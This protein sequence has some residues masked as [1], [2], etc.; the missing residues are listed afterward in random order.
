MKDLRRLIMLV[1]MILFAQDSEERRYGS[2]SHNT[3][4]VPRSGGA[5]KHM[6]Q[7]NDG[8]GSIA[9]KDLSCNPR[10][11]SLEDCGRKIWW[12]DTGDPGGDDPGGDP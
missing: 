1:L 5:D 7:V 11:T 2:P 8:G 4:I 9:M 3:A 12:S 6:W 10:H